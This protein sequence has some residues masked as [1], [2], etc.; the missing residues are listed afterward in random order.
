V[1][2]PRPCDAARSSGYPAIWGSC[3]CV[4]FIHLAWWGVDLSGEHVSS[5]LYRGQLERKRHQRIDAERKAGELRSKE[6][7]ERDRAAKARTA[8]SRSTTPSMVSMKLR[9]AERAETAAAAAGRD[10]ARKQ[11]EAARHAKEEARLQ[12]RMV[13]AERSEAAAAERQ[14]ER[15][16]QASTRRTSAERRAVEARLSAAEAAVIEVARHLRPP[17]QERLRI[18][19]LGS[20][21]SGD[22]RVGREQKRIRAAVESALHRDLVELDVRPAATAP[23]LL[24]GVTKFRP[25]V[26]HFSGH[27]DEALIELEDERD[28]AHP[29]VVVTASAFRSAIRACDEPPL[30]VFLNSCNSAAQL[31]DLVSDEIP[32]AIGMADEIEDV[33]AITYAAQ[34]YAAIA[35]GQSVASSHDSAR[36][37]LELGGLAGRELPTLAAAAGVDPR[38][39]VLV[40]PPN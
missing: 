27:S 11:D 9:E 23:D 8:A 29:G 16:Q 7:R 30:L 2:R 37:A 20:A 22:L 13:A 14:R 5:S 38:E 12:E 31:P 19:V 15:A 36:A 40:R 28:E 39:V 10:A 25:H 1:P 4:L 6:S 34:F 33:D 35:N 3:A 26:V 17:R 21:S 24:D 32:L 18:L